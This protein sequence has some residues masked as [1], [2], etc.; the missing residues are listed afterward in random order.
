MDRSFVLKGNFCFSGDAQTLEVFPRG[1]L[2]CENGLSRGIYAAVPERYQ[3]L[4]VKDYGE[5]LVIPGLVDLHVHAPQFAFRSLGMDLE[6]LEW[7]AK[8][9]FPEEAKYQDLAYADAA[10][11]A[12][13]EDVKHGPNTRACVFA[14]CHVPATIRLMEKLE[15][16]GLCT[17]VGKVNMDRNAP[18]AL[19]EESA[20]ASLKDTAAWVAE[21]AGRFENTGPILT[22]R[23]IP[24]CSGALLMG[25]GELK[26]RAGI[27]AQSHL[28]E[29]PAECEWVLALC[30]GAVGYADAYARFGLFDGEAK[31]VMAHCVW[32]EKEEM[33][34]MR[35]RGVFV[36]HCPQSNANIASGIA[37]VRRFLNMGLKVGLGSDV[38]G[39]CH[40]SIFRAMTDAVQASKLRWRLIDEEDAPLT[41]REAFY[42]A[43]LGGGEF[44]GKVGS[45]APGYEMDAVVIDDRAIA[46]EGMAIEERLARV[47]Y[48]SDDRH[49]R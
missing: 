4:P 39:G 14:T 18:P 2:V 24:S 16:S 29:N 34:L 37:P 8:H 12:F 23:F 28:S 5:M 30:E 48:L 6:L 9:A 41:L 10:Y 21:V 27:P 7:L 3:A 33:K 46:P 11:D 26:R 13:V 40:T 35:E 1:C 31:T 20:E 47:A 36:A 38:A 43:T 32:S 45:F 42:L 44:F 22:P 25:L 19:Q 17:L 15:R 49:I